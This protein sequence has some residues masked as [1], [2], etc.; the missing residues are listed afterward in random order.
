MHTDFTF[1]SVF[2]TYYLGRRHTTYTRHHAP[3]ERPFEQ[4]VRG[5]SHMP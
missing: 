3:A 2:P 4:P 5:R 1:P